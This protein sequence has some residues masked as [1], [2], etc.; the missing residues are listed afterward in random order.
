MTSSQ[1]G[2]LGKIWHE[3][4]ESRIAFHKSAIEVLEDIQA[5]VLQV[6]DMSYNFWLLTASEELVFQ[7]ILKKIAKRIVMIQ[8]NIEE[9]LNDYE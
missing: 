4:V 1:E 7:E 8:E 5:Q 9:E 6:I 3:D 2:W